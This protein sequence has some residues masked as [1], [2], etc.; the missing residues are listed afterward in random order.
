MMAQPL[1]EPRASSSPLPLA[2]KT[3]AMSVTWS[4]GPSYGIKAF[5]GREWDPET[6]LYYYRA[7]YYDPKVGRFISE[8]PIGF[9][10]S[11][12]FFMYVEDIPTNGRDPYGLRGSGV[13]P[14]HVP[15]QSTIADPFKPP[16]GKLQRCTAAW[17]RSYLIY[18]DVSSGKPQSVRDDQEGHCLMH[19]YIR[20]YCGWN[21]DSLGLWW[22][23]RQERQM[24]EKGYKYPPSPADICA[25]RRGI[26]CHPSLSCEVCCTGARKCCGADP[27]CCERL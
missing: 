13:A 11:L 5:T 23:R 26:N 20:R 18:K 1:T 3:S 9:E 25:N 14:W 27:P 16:G 19:C 17:V 7:R 22:E 21:T 24:R 12:H 2:A 8:D 4:G 6:G 10:G 15:G